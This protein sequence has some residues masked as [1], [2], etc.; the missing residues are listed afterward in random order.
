MATRTFTGVSGLSL[1]V[2]LTRVS[3]GKVWQTT[4]GTAV[5]FVA[6]NIANYDIALTPGETSQ[7][8]Y[9]YTVPALSSGE[10]ID[11]VYEYATPS[12]PTVTDDIIDPGLAFV[13]NGD[14]V[15]PGGS[16]PSG[17]TV[18][19]TE[20]RAYL[21]RQA[22]NAGDTSSYDD[23]TI[24]DAIY[25]ALSEVVKE[26]RILKYVTVLDISEDDPA[27]D[28]TSLPSDWRPEMLSGDGV[29]I[30][31]TDGDPLQNQPEALARISYSELISAA[32]QD[33]STGIP[34]AIAF[35]GWATCRVWPTPDDDYKIRAHYLLPEA[36][37]THG[38]SSVT[39]RTPSDI[40][41]P[42][43]ATLGVV[44]LQSNDIEHMP[45][46]DR[47]KAEYEA[48]KRTLSSPGNLG[49]TSFRRQSLSE[50]SNSPRRRF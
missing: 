9:S 23:A 5:T 46:V 48:F 29:T 2:I 3:D 28:L 45:L 30:T 25:N 4:T 8:R 33:T 42:V 12:T 37:W 22:R 19:V 38:G 39:L 15:I 47:K 35:E 24:D 49:A 20:A 14:S 7:D 16:G 1:Y 36:T 34:E 18:S 17:G 40:L 44:K 11:T 10:W 41:Y 27:V 26:F 50:R 6:A 43:L 31:D 13:W 32:A 21:R